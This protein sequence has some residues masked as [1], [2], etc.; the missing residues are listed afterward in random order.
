MSTVTSAGSKLVNQTVQ[1]LLIGGP[2]DGKVIELDKGRYIVIA[3][4]MAYMGQN[5]LQDGRL[6][7]LGFVDPKDHLSARIR[8]LI[9]KTEVKPFSGSVFYNK[10]PK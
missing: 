5:Y 1:C 3:S 6:Y 7:R 8:S 2:A 4:G 9:L 10:K